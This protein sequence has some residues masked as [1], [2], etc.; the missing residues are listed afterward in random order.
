MR[1]HYSAPGTD[2]TIGLP[3]GHRWHG[4]GSISSSG[5]AFIPNMPTEEVY[6]LPDRRR[7]EGTV[8][9]SMPLSVSGRV[10]EGIHLT[11]KDGR[12]VNSHASVNHAL[13]SSL[14]TTDEGAAHLGEVALVPHSSPVAQS[15]VL[16]YDT[17]FDENA[18]CHLALGRAYMGTIDGGESMDE[19]A[20]VAAGGNLSKIHVDFMIGSGNMDIDGLSAEGDAEPVMRS[21]EWAFDVVACRFPTTAVRAD[22]RINVPGHQPIR[23]GCSGLVSHTRRDRGRLLGRVHQH[24]GRIGIACHAAHADLHR[25]A[26]NH[27]QRHQPGGDR[28]AERR[29]RGEFPPPRVCSTYAASSGSGCRL[30]SVPFSAPRSPST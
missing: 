13:L 9:A 27:C 30:S 18:A 10:I 19:A 29:C 2:L 16:F 25:A 23:R 6:T 7:A 17:L 8:T 11:F 28:P 5:I 20:F 14:L 12:V 24:A 21:G 22:A 15:G 4:G 3:A 26:G 1:L